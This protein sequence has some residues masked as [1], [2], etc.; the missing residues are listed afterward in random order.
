MDHKWHHKKDCYADAAEYYDVIYGFKD[1]IGEARAIADRAREKLGHQALSLLDVACGTGKHV[2]EFNLLGI[3]AE[4]MDISS[5][6]IAQAEKNFP[7]MIF[8]SGDMTNFNLNKRFDV[9]TCLFSAIGYCTTIQGLNSAVK[10]MAAHLNP[11]GLLLIEPWFT[12]EQWKPDT[13]HAAIVD[14]PELKIVRMNTSKTEGRLS[15]LDLHYLVGTPED[16]RYIFESH[17]LGLFSQQEM[18][19]AFRNAGLEVEF[20][21]ENPA[22]RGLYSGHSAK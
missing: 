9:V 13:V 11:S 1:Y 19:T 10:S 16:T 12:P 17:R 20:V 2:K 3:K 14:H 6:L 8:H 4:G 22:D 5:G 15:I 18:R 21:R 7:E